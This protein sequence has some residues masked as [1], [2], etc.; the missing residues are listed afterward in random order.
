MKN[1]NSKIERIKKTKELIPLLK[2]INNTKWMPPDEVNY[3][4]DYMSQHPEKKLTK[5]LEYWLIHKYH[6]SKQDKSDSF[7][8]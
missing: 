2:K 8:K 7:N 4:D 3:I 1:N 6:K 5:P